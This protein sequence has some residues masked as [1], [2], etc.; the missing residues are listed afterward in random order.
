MH[1]NVNQNLID[2]NT[3][4]VYNDKYLRGNMIKKT[5]IMLTLLTATAQADP[6]QMTAEQTA[7]NLAEHYVDILI[8]DKFKDIPM[9]DVKGEVKIKKFKHFEYTPDWNHSRITLDT[10]LDSFDHVGMHYQGE[11]YSTHYRLDSD[12]DF[13]LGWQFKKTFGGPKN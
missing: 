7:K 12:G 2:K 8:P 4:K 3:Q 5:I 11:N 10:E 13:Q 6:I 1:Q 9:P